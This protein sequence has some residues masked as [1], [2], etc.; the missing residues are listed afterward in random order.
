MNRSTRA[1]H[2]VGMAWPCLLFATGIVAVLG[3]DCATG[4]VNVLALAV[5]ASFSALTIIGAFACM[6]YWALQDMRHED[7]V[8]KGYFLNG[9][10]NLPNS[11]RKELGMDLK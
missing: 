3:W 6:L 4:R 10:A 1:W 8:C 7:E 5:A 2:I 9:G 11:S